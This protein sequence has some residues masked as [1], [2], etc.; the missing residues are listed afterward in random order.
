MEYLVWGLLIRN[1]ECLLFDLAAPPHVLGGCVFFLGIKMV[2]SP[3]F[4]PSLERKSKKQ[5]H[6]G[7]RTL[8]LH[9]HD[10]H[11]WI[12]WN[13]LR[14]G[15]DM[16]TIPCFIA[17]FYRIH[18]ILKLCCFTQT[19]FDVVQHSGGQEHIRISVEGVME[20][21][22]RNLWKIFGQVGPSATRMYNLMVALNFLKGELPMRRGVVSQA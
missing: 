16:S 15:Y 10:Q 13:R 12:S 17:A 8:M 2:V 18:A 1:T 21:G 20:C 4:A 5:H 11:L 6:P 22:G 14:S 19:L 3:H 7:F 9:H